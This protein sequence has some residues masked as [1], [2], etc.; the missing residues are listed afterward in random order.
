MVWEDDD[1]RD[2]WDKFDPKVMNELHGDQ[3]FISRVM[4]PDKL[5]FLPDDLIKSYK[6][7]VMRGY[8][9][10]LITVFHG[11]PK[12]TELPKDNELRQR[13]QP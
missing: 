3:N 5:S 8:G 7:H 12:V 10:G 4:F 13:W 1:A 11:N 2:V 6:Y 9:C